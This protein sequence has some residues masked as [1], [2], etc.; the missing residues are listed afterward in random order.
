LWQNFQIAVPEV[1]G[2]PALLFPY[3]FPEFQRAEAPSHPYLIIPHY[4][5][6]KLFPKELFAHVV[7]PTEPWDHV[8]SQILDSALV[9]SSSLH[10]LIIAEAY[11]IPA[12]MLRVTENEFLLKYDDYYGGTNRPD[13]TFAR[14]LEEAL[15]MGGERP[16]ECDLKKLY[17][18]FPFEF[19]PDAIPC[20]ALLPSE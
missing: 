13:Y 10:G 8:V 2:D 18:A 16:F 7:Y 5:E 3:L 17:A 9:I 11:G 12:R 1:Y 14:S 19:W 6:E 15:E 4:S 20:Q